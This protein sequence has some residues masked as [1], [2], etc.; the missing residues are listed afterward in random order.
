MIPVH[1]LVMYVF[2]PV[3]G[4]LLKIEGKILHSIL[5][6]VVFKLLSTSSPV[7]R[8]TATKLLLLMVESHQEILV[9]L[10]LSASYKGNTFFS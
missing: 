6:E 4:D 3:S 10:R 7:I 2:F 9:L 1:Q 8:S 5:D